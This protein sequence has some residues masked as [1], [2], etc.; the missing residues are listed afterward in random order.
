M[1]W[2]PTGK[3][4]KG[5][6]RVLTP[7]PGEAARMLE[8]EVSAIQKDRQKAVRDLS[9]KFAG[10]WV[11][12]KGHQTVIGKN[13]GELFVNSS[14]NAWLAQGG[15]GDVLAGY[16]AGWLA[17][18][19]LGEVSLALRYSVWQHGAAA[20]HLQATCRGWTIE[21]LAERLGSLAAEKPVAA[22]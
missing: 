19:D 12:L 20:D 18:P 11:V 14:G 17:Q 8:C 22:K 10:A 1:D 2:L 5:A 9:E 4:P 3:T 15:S 21:Q 13:S 7:H 16:L 6:C